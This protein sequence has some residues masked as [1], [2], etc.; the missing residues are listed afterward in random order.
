MLSRIVMCIVRCRLQKYK[1]S[2]HASTIPNPRL[3]NAQS[4]LL[5]KYT[6]TNTTKANFST[7]FQTDVE[8]SKPQIE[9]EKTNQKQN[10]HIFNML[11]M[12][13]RIR[14]RVVC[15]RP[16]K[17]DKHRST[18][19]SPNA[20]TVQEIEHAR[21]VWKAAVSGSVS[22]SSVAATAAVGA[23]PAAALG[24]AAAAAGF[25]GFVEVAATAAATAAAAPHDIN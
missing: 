15:Y 4:I 17:Y 13:S 19:T 6:T 5:I 16:Q 10:H 2:R 12:L 25:G 14:K 11:Q 20:R 24:A 8:E 18:S 3:I 9:E 1:Y 21:S 22:A 23:A 7:S